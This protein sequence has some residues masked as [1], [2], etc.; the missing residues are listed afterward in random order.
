MVGYVTGGGQPQAVGEWLRTGDLGRTTEELLAAVAPRLTAYKRSRLL[1][2]VDALP[3]MPNGKVDRPAVV[4]I[5][6]DKLAPRAWLMRRSVI[7]RV[8]HC[9]L[10]GDGTRRH[11]HAQPPRRPEQL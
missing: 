3:R 1:L 6:G 10:R 2:R 4:K 7:D 5:V 11:D 8:Q 9:P